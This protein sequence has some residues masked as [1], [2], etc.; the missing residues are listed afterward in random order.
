MEQN[1]VGVCSSSKVECVGMMPMCNHNDIVTMR[2]GNRITY[3]VD[4]NVV[5]P[6]KWTSWHDTKISIPNNLEKFWKQ[7]SQ[8]N[9]REGKLT[10]KDTWAD[11]LANGAISSKSRHNIKWYR[12][13]KSET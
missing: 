13:P 4:T 1:E 8:R 9:Q 6:L 3:N 11:A 12:N 10:S 5:Y 2:C 7:F